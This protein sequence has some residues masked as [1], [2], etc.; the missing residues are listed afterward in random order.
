LESSE[1][2][3]DQLLNDK[4]RRERALRRAGCVVRI[5]NCYFQALYF[6]RNEQTDEAWYYFRVERPDAPTV[7]ATF[8]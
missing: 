6:M 2:A 7:K 3:E 4:Q 5:G 1:N 8:T